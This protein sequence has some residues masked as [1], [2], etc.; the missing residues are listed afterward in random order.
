MCN[1]IMHANSLKNNENIMQ[2]KN[3]KLRNEQWE[4]LEATLLLV[5]RDRRYLKTNRIFFDAVLWVVLNKTPWS[6]L[7]QELGRWRMVYTRFRSWN[8]RKIWHTLA[9]HGFEDPE[10]QRMLDQIVELCDLFN[11]GKES[12]DKKRPDRQVHWIFF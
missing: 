12:R 4:E 2:K 11:L 10:L 5:L 8:R 9:R 6:C 3:E 7:P 1:G